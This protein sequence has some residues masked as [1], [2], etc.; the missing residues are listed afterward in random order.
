MCVS[1]R[2]LAASAERCDPFGWGVTLRARGPDGV[3]ALG[4]VDLLFG[5]ARQTAAP[6]GEH[7][8]VGHA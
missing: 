8:V 3:G 1:R 4:F 2:G 7:R 6:Y 5:V